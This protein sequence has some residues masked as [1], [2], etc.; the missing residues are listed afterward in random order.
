MATA[1]NRLIALILLLTMVW[2]PSIP[3]QAQSQ[4]SL[5]P[6]ITQ[7]QRELNRLD[8]AIQEGINDDL[9]LLTKIAGDLVPGG[10]IVQLL[11]LD[12]HAQLSKAIG[13]KDYAQALSNALEE[14]IGLFGDDIRKN[15]P[16]YLGNAIGKGVPVI[17]AVSDAWELYL[18]LRQRGQ[19]IETR[20]KL[21]QQLLRLQS[22]DPETIAEWG[23]LLRNLKGDPVADGCAT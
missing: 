4:K 1:L 18:V 9:V 13:S 5:R 15:L 22:K 17:D 14:I 16:D 23:H 20:D 10:A 21:F 7:T 3:S 8:Q 12:Q 6:G 2:S 11:R 19:M